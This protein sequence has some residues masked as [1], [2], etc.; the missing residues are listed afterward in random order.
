VALLVRQRRLAEE[1]SMKVRYMSD[2]Q[3]RRAATAAPRPQPV[4]HLALRRT[5]AN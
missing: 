2:A 5:A 1:R 3:A 4:A